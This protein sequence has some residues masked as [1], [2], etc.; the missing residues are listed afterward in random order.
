MQ[1]NKIE[2]ALI[3]LS[4]DIDRVFRVYNDNIMAS[5][6]KFLVIIPNENFD[7]PPPWWRYGH[8]PGADKRNFHRFSG[9]HI[10]GVIDM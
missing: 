8:N 2:L 10:Y 6:R 9:L 1:V 5:L 4:D 7:S 3:H